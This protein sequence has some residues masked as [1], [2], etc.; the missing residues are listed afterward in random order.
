MDYD[1]VDYFDLEEEPE[2]EP[3]KAQIQ[4]RED[5]R[6]FIEERK[7]RVFYSRQLEIKHERKHFHWITNR[8]VH[9]LIDEGFLKAEERGLKTG[10]RIIVVWHRSYRY[11]RRA[12]NRL[13]K[14]VEAF[15]D[16]SVGAALGDHGELLVLSGFAKAQFIMRG[17][18]T[19][20]YGGKKWTETEHN[21]DYIFERDLVVY[22]VEVKNKLGY[23]DHEELKIKIRIC[24]TLG[25]RPVFVVRMMPET[26]IYE[27]ISEGGFVLVMEWQLYP[28]VLSYLVQRIRDELG[29]PV[30]TPRAIQDGTIARFTN[31]HDKNV[32]Q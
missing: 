3:D 27:V 11:Y 19:R 7:E 25:I 28:K 16:S 21:L 23:M 14:L 2:R 6:R 22:G 12:A 8:A 5:L 9:D 18:H 30:D 31:W 10:G 4:A 13:C 26:W 24:K 29:L 20:E 15:A 32:N 17:E 1:D